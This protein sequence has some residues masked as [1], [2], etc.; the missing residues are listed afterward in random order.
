MRRMAA[1]HERTA[2]LLSGG[3]RARRHFM[4]RRV[5]DDPEVN[6]GG[7]RRGL[8]RLADLAAFL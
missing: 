5:F 7:L 8:D 1:A 4:E 3:H 6:E 2:D